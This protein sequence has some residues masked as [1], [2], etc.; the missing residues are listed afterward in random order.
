MLDSTN[1]RYL[2]HRD[3]R[4]D[5]HLMRRTPYEVV[6]DQERL[7][8]HTVRFAAL[9]RDLYL[10]KYS[11]LNPQFNERFF[12]MMLRERILTCRALEQD[13]RIDGFFA[14]FVR[15]R[16][17]TAACIGY[18]QD[19][20]RSRGV[21]RILFALMMAEAAERGLLLNMSAGADHFKLLRGGIPVEEF[22]AVGRPDRLP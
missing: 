14:Y 19:L 20:P 17:M 7:E 1:G 8:P 16:V 3:S 6:R 10:N 11:H 9:Y 18:D 4:R 2:D 5:L 15:D 12:A 21:Y 13:G 22:D